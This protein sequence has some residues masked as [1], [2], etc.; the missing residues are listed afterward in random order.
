MKSVLLTTVSHELGTPLAVIKAAATGLMADDISAQP[1]ALND[2]A[3]SIDVEADHLR[4]LVTDLLDVSRIDGGALRLSLGW[5]DVAEFLHEAV[6]R[7]RPR[8]GERQLLV[9]APEDLLVEFDYSLIDRVIDNL[10]SNAVRYMPPERPV[11]IEVREAGNQI[12]VIV[13]DEGP[14]IPEAELTR[15]F[16]KFHYV[17]GRPAGIGLGLA[18]CRG[19]IEAHNGVIWAE[20]PL[21][22]GRGLAIHLTLPWSRDAVDGLAGERTEGSE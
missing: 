4:R 18:I 3:T 13:A 1:E 7:L 15:V 14:G 8:L 16:E 21:A 9:R 2:L 17:E 5:Y 22:A 12:E 11:T 10:V 6:A 19:I 20:S